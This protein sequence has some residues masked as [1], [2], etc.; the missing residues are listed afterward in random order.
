VRTRDQTR[1]QQYAADDGRGLILVDC[2][3]VRGTPTE[4]EL[5]LASFVVLLAMWTR[6]VGLAGRVFC[7]VD[8]GQTTDAFL[9]GGCLV[10]VFAGPG[11]TA[12]DIICE[13][14]LGFANAPTLESEDDATRG[15]EGWPRDKA[16]RTVA[17]ITNDRGLRR[18]CLKPPCQGIIRCYGSDEFLEMMKK[19]RS[20]YDTVPTCLEPLDAAEA[21]LRETFH[22]KDAAGGFFREVT[23]HRVL[24]AELLRRCCASAEE[25]GE[26]RGALDHLP[27]ELVSGAGLIAADLEAQVSGAQMPGGRVPVEAGTAAEAGT[28]LCAAADALLLARYV[29]ARRRPVDPRRELCWDHRIRHDE[30]QKYNLRAYLRRDLRRDLRRQAWGCT[31]AVGAAEAQPS[32]DGGG[33]GDDGCDDGMDM[34][35]VIVFGTFGDSDEKAESEAEAEHDEDRCARTASDDEAR[36]ECQAAGGLARGGCGGDDDESDYDDDRGGGA[37]DEVGFTAERWFEVQLARSM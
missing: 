11:R 29:A 8:H 12:D 27:W 21:H 32:S 20:P 22:L 33:N 35:P 16:P 14:S 23:W 2:N 15:E 31:T 9:L 36:P 4:F 13:D 18:R 24:A 5:P 19:L 10:V 37:S 17:V 7:V 1:A 6:G 3:N 25:A 26:L 30:K 34:A 28:E